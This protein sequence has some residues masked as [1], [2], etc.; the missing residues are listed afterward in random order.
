MKKFLPKVAFVVILISSIFF[1]ISGSNEQCDG[2]RV[3]KYIT[4]TFFKQ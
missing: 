4:L 1:S 3:V 2:D